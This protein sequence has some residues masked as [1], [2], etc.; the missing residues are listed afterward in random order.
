MTPIRFKRLFC[1]LIGMHYRIALS[2][3]FSPWLLLAFFLPVLNALAQAP[4]SAA[5]ASYFAPVSRQVLRA[6][7]LEIVAQQWL[8]LHRL[9]D[10]TIEQQQQYRLLHERIRDRLWMTQLQVTATASALDNEEERAEQ[11]AG[12]MREQQDRRERRF[13]VAA[14]VVGGLTSVISGIILAQERGASSLDVI[15]VTG[16]IA[17]VGLSLP[18][19]FNTKRSRFDHRRN[20]LAALWLDQNEAGLFPPVVWRF[21]HECPDPATPSLRDQLVG[22][23]KAFG[24]SGDEIY[25]G[26]GGRYSADELTNRAA[27]LDQAEAYVNQIQ[28]ALSELVT[29][30]EKP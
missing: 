28:Q 17:G 30:L 5:L 15:G 25:F 1:S 23:W 11:I 18:S 19:L 12:F 22:Q 24:R 3:F 4:D 2:S 26:V 8:T 6:T 13:T 21:M 29:T 16:G 27:M 14:I 20:A 7:E 9:T 10:R